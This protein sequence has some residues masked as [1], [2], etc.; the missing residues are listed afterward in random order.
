MKNIK[1]PEK[2]ARKKITKQACNKERL[3]GFP[4]NK[5]DNLDKKEEVCDISVWFVAE[6]LDKIF[7]IRSRTYLVILGL[8]TLK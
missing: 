8:K 6:L 7:T 2:I 4:I 3:V 5:E 1:T